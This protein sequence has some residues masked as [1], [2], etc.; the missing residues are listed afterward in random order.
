MNHLIGRDGIQSL[1]TAGGS[2]R[3]LNESEFVDLRYVESPVAGMSR[4]S[5]LTTSE[6]SISGGNV[7]SCFDNKPAL[8]GTSGS[9]PDCSQKRGDS[10]DSVGDVNSSSFSAADQRKT[11]KREIDR[12]AN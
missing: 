2:F 8:G 6:L 7:N 1:P 4:S 10:G 3:S 11:F 9:Y 5:D 12:A